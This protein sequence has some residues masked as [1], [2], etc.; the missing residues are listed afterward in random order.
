[1]REQ[2]VDTT[3]LTTASDWMAELGQQEL[4]PDQK[5]ALT[6]WLRESPRNVREMLEATLLEQDIRD[7]PVSRDQ[8]DEWVKEARESRAPSPLP[9]AGFDAAS[10]P[11]RAK[12]RS[13][14]RAWSIAASVAFVAMIG[15][16]AYLHWQDGRYSTDLGE[17]K[18]LTLA[19]GS[20][21]TLN[22]SSTIKVD[23][24]AH[25]RNIELIEGEAFFR[26]AHDTAR[27]FDVTARDATAR[28]VG[29]QFN[30][31]IAPQATLVS[32]LEGVVDVRERGPEADQVL[33]LQKG[34]EA[35]VDIG[36]TLE[37]RQ[38]PRV[39]K[40]AHATPMRAVAWTRGRVEF[41]G[42]PLIDVLGEFQRYRSFDVSVD[43]PLRQMRLTGSFD[44]QDLES[45][46]QYIATLPGVV[47]ERTGTHSFLVR[48][49]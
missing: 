27:P 3:R 37:D 1:M 42:T 9:V 5:A 30:V 28:A 48:E 40:T 49:R 17:Q 23:F 39:V 35:T 41:D 4:E 31:R 6:D 38:S 13:K 25:R 12:P 21:V 32:V 36:Q 18:I 43:E 34:E 16:A 7:V 22:T 26:V 24:S 2:K 19:D 14:L 33:R 45:A 15:G 8:L 44:A 11:D 10:Q 20:I 46:L 29:T 47:V